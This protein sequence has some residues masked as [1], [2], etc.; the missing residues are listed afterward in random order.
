[1]AACA[2]Q[3]VSGD[4]RRQHQEMSENEQNEKENRKGHKTRQVKC[5]QEI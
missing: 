4:C 5:K 2:V 3:N 1:V